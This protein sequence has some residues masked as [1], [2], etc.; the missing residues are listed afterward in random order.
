MAK[1]VEKNVENRLAIGNNVMISFWPT[2]E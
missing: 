1:F 2:N